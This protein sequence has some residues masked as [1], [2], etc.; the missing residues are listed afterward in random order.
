VVTAKMADNEDRLKRAEDA[1]RDNKNALVQVCK[2][3]KLQESEKNGARANCPKT[4]M[5][6]TMK[7]ET[8]F[9]QFGISDIGVS[10]IL[11]SCI[12]VFGHFALAPKKH[13]EQKNLSDLSQFK[14]RNGS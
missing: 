5:S 13:R 12:L 2:P 7:P 11:V 10:D 8:G 14:I 1:A 6:E 3:W 4:Q 9:G